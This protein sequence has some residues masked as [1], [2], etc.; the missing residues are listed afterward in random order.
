MQ[1]RKLEKVFTSGK[2]CLV[3]PAELVTDGYYQR[4]LDIKRATKIAAEWDWALVRVIKVGRR[5]NGVLV[6]L[7]GQH[8]CWAA[9]KLGIVELQ[10]EIFDVPTVEDEARLFFALNSSSKALNAVDRFKAAV[11]KG[12]KFETQI[13]ELLATTW[14][15][16][17]A[18]K[19]SSKI[20]EPVHC[21]A[22]LIK[23]ARS[24][25]KA[26]SAI[27][28]VAAE[29]CNG[30]KTVDG[31]LL[32]ALHDVETL[33]VKGQTLSSPLWKKRLVGYSTEQIIHTYRRVKAM[34]GGKLLRAMEIV[35]L[36]NKGLRSTKLVLD[37][38][39]K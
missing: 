24:D 16:V 21:A 20:G 15:Y 13:A 4:P 29:M 9:E 27:W 8:T 34:N 10:A 37:P 23:L 36:L 31:Y 7:D 2:H 19:D 26:L 28:P 6:T 3:N 35:D 5:P 25:M 12:A 14:H 30:R 38:G 1:T 32:T 33:L 39:N 11:A 17:G 22:V 18:A